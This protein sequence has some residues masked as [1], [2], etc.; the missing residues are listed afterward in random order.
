MPEPLQPLVAQ[1]IAALTNGVYHGTLQPWPGQDVA[2]LIA[3]PEAPAAPA[4]EA[5]VWRTHLALTLPHLGPVAVGL[6]LSPTGLAVQLS[7][8]A[9]DT[10]AL[11]RAQQTALRRGLSAAALSVERVAIEL[12][13]AGGAGEGGAAG[14]PD[15]R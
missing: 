10:V 3:D 8:T 13:A 7:G 11:F 4:P 2:W 1:Q 12:T 5:H 15:V 14:G 6:T 9:P